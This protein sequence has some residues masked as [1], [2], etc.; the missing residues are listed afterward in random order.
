M[1]RGLFGWLP[2]SLGDILYLAA[3]IYL[4][5]KIVKF[6]IAIFKK[7][8]GKVFW[9]NGLRWLVFYCLAVYAVFNI[10][11]GLNYNRLGMAYQMR[12]QMNPYSTAELQQV[13]SILLKRLD[14]SNEKALQTREMYAGKKALFNESYQCYQ[15]AAVQYP[16]I[17]YAGKSVKSSLYRWLGNY[18]GYTGYYNPFTGEAQVNTTVP[19][20]VLPFTTCHEMGHQL[21]YAKENE[22][23]F[24]GYLSAKSSADPAF[25]YSVYFDFIQ[26]WHT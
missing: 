8:A 12:L 15:L 25:T 13:V 11:W 22:A 16:H 17:S 10:F 24:A 5:L 23:N 18:L 4:L 1:L 7:K 21:G 3:G 2:F 6:F 14:A 9:W 19:V 26:L 20:F